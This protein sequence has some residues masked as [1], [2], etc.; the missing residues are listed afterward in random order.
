MG[1]SRRAM[2][3]LR[4]LRAR[5][6]LSLGTY[7]EKTPVSTIFPRRRSFV[8]VAACTLSLVLHL[9]AL[10]WAQSDTADAEQPASVAV[11]EEEEAAA[12]IA[13]SEDEPQ[14]P[15]AADVD[16]SV[17]PA[18]ATADAPPTTDSKSEDSSATELRTVAV[19]AIS[20]EAAQPIAPMLVLLTGLPAEG[21]DAGKPWGAL[22][23]SD[24]RETVKVYCVPVSEPDEVLSLVEAQMQMFGVQ[25]EDGENGIKK[26][27]TPFGMTFHY[28]PRDGWMYVS[29]SD[30]ALARLPENPPAAFDQI[31]AH[32]SLGARI[33]FRDMPDSDRQALAA[34]LKA[35]NDED[36]QYAKELL[37]ER[38]LEV[39]RHQSELRLKEGERWIASLEE[40]TVG[41]S[42]DPQQQR[43]YFDLNCRFQPDS[44]LA[45]QIA[46]AGQ[47]HTNFAGFYQPDATATVN[48]ASVAEPVFHFLLDLN[49][50]T[51]PMIRA[52][53]ERVVS[54]QGEVPDAGARDNLKA[55]LN[56]LLEAVQATLESEEFD[57][58]ASYHEEE[59]G[60]TVVAGGLVKQPERIEAA[61]RKLE[62]RLPLDPEQP[63]I[64]WNAAEHAGVRF[65]TFRA[66]VPEADPKWRE[67]FGEKL[68]VTVGIGDGAVYLALG[69]DNL[70][71]LQQAIDASKAEPK[72]EVPPLDASAALG[73]FL[74]LAADW[75]GPD[76]AALVDDA[77]AQLR[78]KAPD[79]DR[80]RLTAT[81]TDG[82]LRYRLEA[83]DGVLEALSSFSLMAAPGAEQPMLWPPQQQD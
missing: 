53:A 37:N 48:L 63:A 73:P 9:A 31:L 49:R 57:G 30:A 34:Y 70:A 10:L 5:H 46:A 4:R 40:V 72:K 78:E 16:D 29:R 6:T 50:N 45:K 36:L 11:I 43:D 27:S 14:P 71:A 32:Y 77:A 76:F 75:V 44:D 18:A 82:G 26:L 28:L 61:L 68:D 38:E 21:I 51:F 55:A 39:Y 66:M 42:A 79:H 69:S 23:M 41:F 74:P 22:A 3:A 2:H 47:P 64:Q 13:P 20:P 12:P 65:H 7:T 54:D 25:L 35:V 62:P 24:G 67:R 17:A 83:E 8:L 80:V 59:N 81:L 1:V 58:A 15:A 33:D 60:V 19:V 52:Q 56:E